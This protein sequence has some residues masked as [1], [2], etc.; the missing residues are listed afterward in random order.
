V[1]PSNE[2]KDFETMNRPLERIGEAKPSGKI[3]LFS[4]F[5]TRKNSGFS[6]TYES[7]QKGI[8]KIGNK[9]NYSSVA[10]HERGV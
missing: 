10:G 4:C 5:K 7:L 8:Q 2:R 3:G 1:E 9:N 6:H